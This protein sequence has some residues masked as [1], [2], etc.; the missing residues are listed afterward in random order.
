[1]QGK[2]GAEVG[3]FILPYSLDRTD[4]IDRRDRVFR[5]H[6]MLL[7]SPSCDNLLLGE[8]KLKVSLVVAYGV[9][10]GTFRRDHRHKMIREY[11]SAF[12]GDDHVEVLRPFL[13]PGEG[14]VVHH[15]HLLAVGL[16]QDG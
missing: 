6:V 7:E 13:L 16:G 12:H 8:S 2:L 3:I 1:M 10:D 11:P 5:V 9:E 15:A 4:E 14:I